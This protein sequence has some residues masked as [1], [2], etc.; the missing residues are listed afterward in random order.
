[1]FVRRTFVATKNNTLR[2]AG[3]T[4]VQFQLS[5]AVYVDRWWARRTNARRSVMAVAST[6]WELPPSGS[7]TGRDGRSSFPGTGGQGDAGTPSARI[8]DDANRKTLETAPAFAALALRTG[9]CFDSAQVASVHECDDA[10]VD[11][12]RDL[13]YVRAPLIP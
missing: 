11:R 12:D 2:S 3:V 1:Y 8:K 5:G 13:S 7:S 4:P 9:A 6:G 10:D